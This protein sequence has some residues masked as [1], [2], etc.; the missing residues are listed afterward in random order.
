MKIERLCAHGV[1]KNISWGSSC[2][3]ASKYNQYKVNNV[4][5]VVLN[6]ISNEKLYSVVFGIGQHLIGVDFESYQMGRPYSNKY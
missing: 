2:L 5:H 6:S 1:S 3:N 4:K